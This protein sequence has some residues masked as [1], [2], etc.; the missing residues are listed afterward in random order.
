MRLRERPE[1]VDVVVTEASLVA[2]LVD[3]AVH[4]ADAHASVARAWLPEHG[5][6]VFAPGAAHPDDVAGFGVADPVGVLLTA[7]LL[8]GE[9]LKRR[10]ASRTLERA[11]GEAVRRGGD[12]PRET[13]GFTDAVLELLPQA[14]TDFELLDGVRR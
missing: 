4:F 1:E 12:A 7:S 6:G 11:V 5:P 2:G 8:L 14:R 13:R 9:G 10:S 3:A